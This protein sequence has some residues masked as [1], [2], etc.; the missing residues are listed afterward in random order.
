MRFLNRFAAGI[1]G[2]FSRNRVEAELDEE[3]RAYLHAAVQQKRARGFSE[4]DAMRAARVEFGSLEANK[5]RVRDVGW[6]SIVF[7]TSQDVSYAIR[8]LR[9]KPGYALT[10]VLMLGLGVGANAAVFSIVD[11]AMIRPL[12]YHD[13]DQLVLIRQI[14]RRGTGEQAF[15]IGMTWNQVDRWRDETEIFSGIATYTAERLPVGGPNG[16]VQ[17]YVSSVSADMPELLGIRP[18]VGRTFIVDDARPDPAVVLLSEDFW[19]MAY[20]RDPNVLGGSLSVD[21]KRYTIIGVMPVTLRWGV[22]GEGVVAWLPLDERSAR[23]RGGR[24]FIGAIARLHPGLT[25]ETATA[26]MARAI[27]RV[28]GEVPPGQRYDA[29]LMPLDSRA[30]SDDMNKTR[31]ALAALL[32]AVAFVF[33]IA[34]ANVTNLVLARVL[35]RRR[36]IS[37]RAALGASRARIFRQLFTEGFVVVACGGV[38]AV[39]L[40]LWTAQVVP[41]LV[42]KE[43]QL[44]DANPLVIDS[45]TLAVCATALAVAMAMCCLIPA[46]RG[47]SGELIV[48]LEGSQRIAGQGTGARRLRGVLQAAQVAL[49]LV[50]LTGAGLLTTSFVRMIQ[51]KAG[52]DVDHLVAATIALPKERYPNGQAGTAFFEELLSRINTSPGLRGIYGPSPTNGFSGRFV[53]F[54]REAER[55][56]AGALSIYFVAPNY[57]ALTGTPLKAGR[58]FS[59]EEASAGSAVGLIDERAASLYWPGQSPIGQ[60][61]RYS[62]SAPWVTVIGVVGH[63]K[64]HWFTDAKGTIQVYVPA[65]LNPLTP[66][67]RP[68]LIRTDL[69]PSRALAVLT[70]TARTI[71]PAVQLEAAPVADSYEGVFKQPRFFV[72]LMSLFA[73]LALLTASVGLYGLVNYAVAQ[74]TREIG[75][76]MALGA[77]FQRVVRLVLR[78][79]MVPVVAGIAVGTAGSWWLSRYLSSLLYQITPHDPQTF[80]LVTM[81]LVIVAA[82][83][84][85]LPARAATRIDPIVTL[86]AE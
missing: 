38:C 21:S 57:F 16:V 67:H 68:I 58:F 7:A 46:L 3:L 9:L 55:V 29:D 82:T 44:F 28:D 66:V 5:D 1:K 61:F 35:D 50:L 33:L 85:Y 51:T 2:L 34:C 80:S 75:V 13:P 6:E 47:A 37:V 48:G 64:T 52:Y 77:D 19:A 40:A 12:P 15:Q 70:A 81:L 31:R 26:E 60:Q 41:E 18:I 22:G 39:A 24:M 20:K 49:T 53:A 30:S 71:D 4:Q 78:D 63:I 23:G 14:L 45:R 72:A 56:P 65:Q 43:L 10:A 25:L 69:D 17:R 36:E 42:P 62:P 74:R 83:A 84:A 32:T 79:A 8:G 59:N 76:R 86:R 27:A 11:A 73:A 54:G